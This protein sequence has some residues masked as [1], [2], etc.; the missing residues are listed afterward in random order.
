[1]HAYRFACRRV[2]RLSRCL[3]MI[4]M[5][6]ALG[7]CNGINAG[8]VQALTTSL[9]PGTAISRP[10]F[11]AIPTMSVV[12]GTAAWKTYRNDRAGYAVDY[13]A[14][15]TID[16]RSET[17][18][19]SVT[20]FAPPGPNQGG[21]ELTVITQNETASAGEIRDMPNTRCQPVRVGKMSGTR[22]FDTLAFNTTT[23]LIDQ[24]KVY[25]LAGSGKR[26]SQSI[27]QHFLDTLV[28]K[29]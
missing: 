27:Y 26:L 6:L 1:M 17:D 4:I 28:L 22:C 19:T 5:A 25:I 16:E 20:T 29:P 7:A 8:F 9:P 15:W 12:P 24:G 2:S 11:V 21:I 10:T 23:T 18:G 3:I 13:P 14:D